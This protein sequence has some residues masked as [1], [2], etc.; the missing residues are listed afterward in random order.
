METPK[1]A[2][3]KDKQQV[4]FGKQFK[5]WRSGKIYRAEDYGHKA[6]PFGKRKK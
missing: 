4:P 2:T 5:H 1:K 3:P 6:W